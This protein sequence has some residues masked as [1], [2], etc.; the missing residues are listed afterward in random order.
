[1]LCKSVPCPCYLS[2]GCRAGHEN[3]ARVKQPGYLHRIPRDWCRF[4]YG[5][6]VAFPRCRH[7][8]D[9]CS[10]SY[11]VHWFHQSG[12]HRF[13]KPPVGKM[14]RNV[15]QS[16]PTSPYSSSPSMLGRSRLESDNGCGL[17]QFPAREVPPYGYP[18]H[19]RWE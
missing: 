12:A 1:M 19:R 13:F 2:L 6:L 9:A 7:T 5:S 8:L 15:L 17:Q 11:S 16:R 4:G 10:Q 3:F 18:Q 14:L